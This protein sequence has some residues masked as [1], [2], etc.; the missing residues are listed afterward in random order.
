MAKSG[1]D[2][3]WK[4]YSEGVSETI[5][6]LLES[7]S[8]DLNPDFAFVFTS[9]E[10]DV[11][12]L[13]SALDSKLDCNYVGCTTAGEITP[14]GP[15]ENTLT[16]M[17]VDREDIEFSISLRE[18]IH[19]QPREKGQK[20]AEEVMEDLD[21][22]EN[23]ALFLLTSGVT[24]VKRPVGYKVLKGLSSVVPSEI[25]ISGGSSG[26][27]MNLKK[28]FQFANGKLMEGGAIAVSISTSLPVESVQAHGK[29]NA[30]ATGVVTKSE[31]R[32]IVEIGD[33]SAAEFYA[34]AIDEDLSELE[35]L[36]DLPLAK[37]LSF[38]LSYLKNK[39]LRRD[40]ITVGQIFNYSL[41]YA[42]SE[43]LGPKE[44]IVTQPIS[45]TD[46]GG[47][48]LSRSI[49]EN[50]VIKVLEGER[51][52]IVSAGSRAVKDISDPVLALFADCATR[53]EL[54]DETE[55]DNEVSQITEEIGENF[56]GWYAMGEVGQGENLLCTHMNQ[57]VSGLVIGPKD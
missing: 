21:D 30:K 54:L 19:D 18:E 28:T 23:N 48:L 27:N 7:R 20:I 3:V 56:A 50:Q 33:R 42:I 35:K 11:R 8:A 2:V 15:K 40:P 31:G 53:K 37:E 51:E 25:P 12:E 52:E 46:R 6:E 44:E 41:E 4:K 1:V 32:E 16:A 45:V 22:E 57:T 9:P 24:R 10:V 36:Y 43:E 55:L 17:F 29:D 13:N 49:E 34:D 47:I 5:D 14:E 39:I 26:D 38:G